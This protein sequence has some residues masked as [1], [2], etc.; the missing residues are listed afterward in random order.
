M[1]DDKHE[2]KIAFNRAWIEFLS[3]FLTVSAYGAGTGLAARHPEWFW[4]SVPLTV[5]SALCLYMASLTAS[6]AAGRIFAEAVAARFQWTEDMPRRLIIDIVL[7]ALG[8]SIAII[9]FRTV[10]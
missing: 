2:R 7:I 9:A 3:N 4:N 5:I 10:A 1:K 6:T 8:S